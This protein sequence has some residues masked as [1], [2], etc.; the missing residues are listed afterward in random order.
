MLGIY[1]YSEWGGEEGGGG[2]KKLRFQQPKIKEW[3]TKCHKYNRLGTNFAIK[4]IL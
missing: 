1:R 3:G 2:I 4:L